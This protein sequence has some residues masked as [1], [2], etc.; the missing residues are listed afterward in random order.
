MTWHRFVVTA[1]FACVALTAL[2]V[3]DFCKWLLG[4][5]TDADEQEAPPTWLR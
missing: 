1:A 5:A 2:A 3:H 4:L